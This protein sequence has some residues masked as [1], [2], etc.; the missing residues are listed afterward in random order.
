MQVTRRCGKAKTTVLV[1]VV[2]LV[3]LLSLVAC[4]P[5]KPPVSPPADKWAIAGYT[6]GTVTQEQIVAEI[7]WCFMKSTEAGTADVSSSKL[8]IDV[9]I[10]GRKYNFALVGGHNKANHEDELLGGR[11]TDSAGKLIFAVYFVGEKHTD[12]TLDTAIYFETAGSPAT[13]SSPAVAGKK[14]KFSMGTDFSPYPLERDTSANKMNF[15]YGVLNGLLWFKEGSVPRYEYKLVAGATSR[16]YLFELDIRKTFRQ[17]FVALQIA[18]ASGDTFFGLDLK[19]GDA[20]LTALLG[21]TQDDLYDDEK[22]GSPALTV[23]MLTK[24][25]SPTLGTF[26]KGEVDRVTISVNKLSVNDKIGTGSRQVTAELTLSGMTVRSVALASADRP[27]ATYLAGFTNFDLAGEIL[28]ALAVEGL[29]VKDEGA[30]RERLNS[31]LFDRDSFVSP[32]VILFSCLDLDKDGR[33]TL[34]LKDAS[35]KVLLN[36][37][38]DLGSLLRVYFNGDT[39]E[40]E[41]KIADGIRVVIIP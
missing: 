20:M 1:L 13:A 11:L 25:G 5:K 39:T 8:S 38:E 12:G 33:L 7:L 27:S 2:T 10:D 40:V 17:M 26:G 3:A 41:R 19:G 35:L 6:A 22:F 36:T 28:E 30:F 29:T 24:L 37:N 14:V 18:Q 16:H 15:Y 23:D 21:I 9:K 4:N 31:M 34:C 32:V